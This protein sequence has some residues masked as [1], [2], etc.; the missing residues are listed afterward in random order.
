M[1]CQLCSAKFQLSRLDEETD[2]FS[3]IEQNQMIVSS[4]GLQNLSVF[5]VDY[6]N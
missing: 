3:D 1:K 5:A 2:C 6:H 4:D